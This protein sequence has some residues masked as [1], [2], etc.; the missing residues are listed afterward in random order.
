MESIVCVLHDILL[1]QVRM[2]ASMATREFLESS[3][4][5]GGR[6][7]LPVL[8]APMCLNRYGCMTV[9]PMCQNCSV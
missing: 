8:L 2:A 7:Y 5:G 6:G 3:S 4:S 9:H 1:F